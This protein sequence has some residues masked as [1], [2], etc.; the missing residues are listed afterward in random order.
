MKTAYENK[1]ETITMATDVLVIGGGAAAVQ[2]A[3]R[4]SGAGYPVILAGPGKQNAGK[5]VE[6][7]NDSAV[8][9]VSGMPGDFS[10]K[11]T[12]QGKT[13]IKKAGAI[14]VA[15]DLAVAPLFD[16]YGLT[17]AANVLS[18]SQFE[19]LM[20]DDAQRGKALSGEKTVAFL[21]GFAKE[22]NPML[23]RR[24]LTC[25]D[26][27]TDIKGCTTYVYIN[28]IKV[29]DDGLERLYKKGRDKG[30]TYF[31]LQ[32]APTVVQDKEKLTVTFHDP[33]IRSDIEV[34]PDIIVCEESLNA[35]P[36][37]P[38]LARV[39]RIDLGPA[40]F[41]QKE[42][43]HRLPVGSNREGI[44]VVGPAR[45]VA[46]PAKSGSDV[47]NMLLRVKALIGD[48]N[49]SV[50]AKAVV[51][52]D[53]C[54]TCLTCFRCCPHGAIS[55]DSKA[56]ISAAA[57]QGC[58]ICAS[59]C[60]MDAIQLM[61]FT[62]AE[63]TDRVKAAA[64]TADAPKIVAFCCQNSAFEAGQMA[65]AFGYDLPKGLQMIKVPCA[66]K[67]DIQYILNAL[68]EAD[69]VLVLACHTGN[70]KSE[71]GNTYAKWRVND[72]YRKLEMVGI[73]KER[74]VF[75]TLASNMAC[76]FAKIARDMENTIR[77]L[78]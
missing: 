62:D 76:D 38:A 60:P 22:G 24:I 43:V 46:N 27:A 61:D 44:F 18:L 53:K 78:F 40:G 67:I 9:E 32:Q 5:G 63:M 77:E 64:K 33:V 11:L 49:L 42:N 2:A 21:A 51:D 54:V 14:V 57:C 47:E 39:L 23:M 13:V 17:P 26:A 73:K 50:A 55:W 19:A 66:G 29:A 28:N 74:L 30:A 45:D 25:V 52:R 3:N 35:D 68:V 7:L 58:G 41:L 16:G 1:T 4:L 56:V 72:A 37:H 6:V 71:A 70:C 59:E 36:T 8:T 12:A 34:S 65:G 20:N 31:K 48:G 10:V 69:G 75:A 15:S